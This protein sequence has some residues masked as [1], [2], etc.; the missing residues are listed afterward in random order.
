MKAPL[1]GPSYVS[2]S[3]NLAD[4]RLVNLYQQ[5]VESKSASGKAVGALIGAPGLDLAT[6]VGSGPIRA[7]KAANLQ[8]VG[9]N[10]YVV[11]GQG[12]YQLNTSYASAHLG[13]LDTLN[14]GP[15]TIVS[16]GVD[17]GF[18]AG[19]NSY[20]WNPAAG[21]HRTT[22]PFA[23]TTNAIDSTL[24]PI[25]AAE[26]DGFV[27]AQQPFT[28]FWFQSDLKDLST[29]DAL[30]FAEAS[31]DFDNVVKVA[32]KNREFVLHKQFETEFWYNAG[33]AGFSFA[34]LDGAYLELGLGA[35]ASH[36]KVGENSFVFLAQT[37]RGEGFAVE[38]DAHQTKRISTHAL[39]EEWQTYGIAD[40]V[41]YVYS[42]HGHEFWVL[43]FPSGDTTWVYDRTAS[44]ALGE[45][46][47][48]Q[49]ARFETLTGTLHR[50]IGQCAAAFNHLVLV[51]D[52]QNGNIYTY[53]LATLLD[54]SNQRKWLRSFRATPKPL[55][56]QA[57]FS[58][59][60]LDMQTGIGIAPTANPLVM[61]RWSDDGGHLWSNER[62]L[63]AGKLGET[64]KR[65][66][67]TRLGQTKK[68]TGLDRIFEISSTDVFPVT[69][70]DC[71][72]ELS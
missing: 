31:G 68:T 4:N 55:A 59:F 13:D 18:F 51:G 44:T 71:D 14:D 19:F 17:I 70:I 33:T 67:T 16:N 15:V 56:Q 36:C 2:R 8:G 5:I 50:H 61:L 42:Q 64:A 27:V 66:R 43:N 7:M 1:F 48:H 22:M 6:T 29:W 3:T 38:L 47:W 39:E 26:L 24:T 69:L 25:T 58:D 63:P 40:A 54:N 9:D 57:T 72:I 10:L 37:D 28:D 34:R 41:G 52:Y 62:K 11:S 20:Y 35:V 32:Q 45:P 60:Q 30:N 23:R 12:V 21:F 49:R 65:V 53:N 46:C